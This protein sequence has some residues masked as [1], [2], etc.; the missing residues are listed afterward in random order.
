MLRTI[1]LSIL[2]L[3]TGLAPALAQQPT[4]APHAQPRH[5]GSPDAHD[6]IARHFFP[7]ELIMAHQ[8]DI[9]L[10]EDQREAI[11][12]AVDEAHATVHDLKWD[13]QPETQVLAD[14]VAAES[15]DEAAILAQAERVMDMEK[16]IKLIHM[17][18]V[19]K[20]KNLLTAEQRATLRELRGRRRHA[21]VLAPG[22]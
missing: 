21:P 9:G 14:L 15:L 18:L 1:L 5:H 22:D 16:R 10:A 6:V 2:I 19:I 17:S 11:K 7:P 13:L 12:S 3:A 4:P 8:R 20:I